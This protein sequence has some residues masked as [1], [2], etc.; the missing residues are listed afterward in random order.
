VGFFNSLTI[1]VAYNL[2]MTTMNVQ[3]F[4]DRIKRLYPSIQAETKKSWDKAVKPIQ[5]IKVCDVDDDVAVQYLE[6]GMSNWSESTVKQRIGYLKGLWVKGYRKRI[7]KGENPWLDLDDGLKIARREPVAHPW[8]FYEYYHNDPYFVC[9]WYSGMRIGE[10]AGIYP[11]NIV[12]DAQIPYFN[13]KH[14]SNRRLK[15][16]SSIRMVPIH[17]ACLPYV[18]QLYLS[19]D[20]RPGRSWSE[21]FRKNMGLPEGEGAHTLRHNFATRMRAL[22]VHEYWIDRLMGHQRSSETS[23]YGT[24]DLENLSEQLYKLR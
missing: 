13:L 16:N 5:T 20:S 9:L 17:P 4:T 3:E 11:E 6:Q 19:K 8:E 2:T 14:Q 15:N 24:F 18:S 10:L 12:T 1:G 7:Y 22:N 21:T 23:R